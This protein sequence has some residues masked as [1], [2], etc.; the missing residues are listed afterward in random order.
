MRRGDERDA[1]RRLARVLDGAETGDAELEAVAR[2]L[3][4]AAAAARVE[5][6]DVEVE[7]ALGEAR[8]RAPTPA[9]GGVGRS[10]IAFGLGVAVAAAAV[11]LLVL[12]FAS[13]PVTVDVQAR[14]LSALG[15]SGN[16]VRIL[17][18]VRPGPGASFP[19]SVRAGWLDP[20]H[21]QAR[22]TQSVGGRVVAETLVDHRR[23]TRYDPATGTA[24][25]AASCAALASGCAEAT[26]PVAFYRRALVRAR[27]ARAQEVT[28]AGRRVYRFRL[29]VQQL[30]DAVRIV[31]VVS[32]DAATF[33]PVRIEWRERTPGGRERTAAVI[34]VRTIQVVPPGGAPP[35]ALAI[36]LPPGTHVTQ[37]VAPATPV[38]LLAS[39]RISLAQ[40]RSLRPL[41]LWL[42]RRYAGNR[43]AAIT[44]LRYTGGSAL[45]LR[46]G[47][48][49]V[50]DYGRVV[51]PPLIG[52]AL[53]VKTA[54]FGS[55]V[56]R[57]YASRHGRLIG[58]L[59]RAGGGTAAVVAPERTKETIFAA[60]AALRP[61]DVP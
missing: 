34:E 8:R 55:G 27:S 57:F 18:I 6:T 10:G 11:L 24:T 12:P 17:E 51:P 22:W 29:P 59:N 58:E 46:Y 43:L 13:G 16:L 35:N 2:L 44:L 9:A 28:V 30:P 4:D 26:D 32:I 23:V 47:P 33:R 5:V 31:Q 45:R 54:P 38:R 1:A 56:A 60:V 3:R 48:F 14:A 20:S 15:G 25:V 42:G 41:P 19:A 53:P 40:A 49:T 50:W 61:I 36:E 37:L 21:D 39:R 7:Q 52:A